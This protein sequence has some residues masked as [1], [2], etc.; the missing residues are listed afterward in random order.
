MSFSIDDPKGAEAFL[1]KVE[2]EGKDLY[3]GLEDG[4]L[5]V[6]SRQQF[7]QMGAE[8]RGEL[9]R[10]LEALIA[11][12][13]DSVKYQKTLNKI[14]AV[15]NE[16]FISLDENPNGD[17]AEMPKHVLKLILSQT[18]PKDVSFV[19]EVNK[20]F[21]LAAT[22]DVKFQIINKGQLKLKDVLPFE[23]SDEVLS[24]IIK[25]KDAC[26]LL[27]YAD[28]R[29]FKDFNDEH[30]NRLIE[31]CPNINALIINNGT[32]TH[33]G[34]DSIATMPK[35]TTLDLKDNQIGAA[36]AA[37]IARMLNVTTL[38]LAGNEIG[39]EGAASIAKMLNVTTLDLGGNEIGAEG[40][41]SIAKMPNVTTL[42]LGEQSNRRCRGDIDR[43]DAK[44]Q[45]T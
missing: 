6:I 31:N 33:V 23:T 26:K 41:E 27:T 12:F 1:Q 29:G 7:N 3:P 35:V 30:L 40:A 43:A 25:D 39:E 8:E 45:N 19:R 34:A 42:L 32:I 5:V 2:K 22:P 18:S 44:R 13:T 38:V 16:L 11:N 9:V 15:R 4:K 14:R 24:W 37:S 10:N 21:K 36:G 20:Q 17:I 28:F